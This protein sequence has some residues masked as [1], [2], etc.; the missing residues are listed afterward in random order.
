VREPG[1]QRA[2]RGQLL[3]LLRGLLQAAT[4]GHV[5]DQ[6]DGARRGSVLTE[7]AAADIPRHALT[8]KRLVL[9]RI[10][11]EPLDLATQQALERLGERLLLQVRVDVEQ[12]AALELG[13]R[14]AAPALHRGIPGSD[15]PLTIKTDHAFTQA[16]Q[17]VADV[18]ITFVRGRREGGHPCALPLLDTRDDRGGDRCAEDER[19][20]N[21]HVGHVEARDRGPHE[22]GI[23]GCRHRGDREPAPRAVVVRLERRDQRQRQVEVAARTAAEVDQ[24]QREQLVHHE[25]VEVESQGR[26]R[27]AAQ[28]DLDR[29]AVGQE[30]DDRGGQ[31]ARVAILGRY[32]SHPGNRHEHR[33][34][35]E[36]Q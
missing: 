14:H 34:R 13:R 24:H 5:L 27:P 32:Q 9:D 29:K 15:P 8:A 18:P 21:Q 31:R 33:E 28:R 10:E 20:A 19:D 3:R 36:Q 25:H 30:Y 4:L 17:H 11:P 16:L 12:A 2:Q 23:G 35:A 1:R 7:Q 6:Q 26:S 22:H